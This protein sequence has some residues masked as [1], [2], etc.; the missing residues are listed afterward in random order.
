MNQKPDPKKT[1][2]A[3]PAKPQQGKPA[4]AAPKPATP[5]KA[6]APKPK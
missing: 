1:P 4:T 2:A 3:P 6:P 5:T